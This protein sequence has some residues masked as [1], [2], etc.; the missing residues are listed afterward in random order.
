MKRWSVVALAVAMVMAA[1]CG[2]DDADAA[3]TQ[4]PGNTQSS[5]A[6]DTSPPATSAG[7]GNATTAAPPSDSGDSDADIAVVTIG[8]TT[9]RFGLG[10]QAFTRCDYNQFSTG[11]VFAAMVQ[12][13]DAGEPVLIEGAAAANVL[14][15]LNPDDYADLG[16]DAPGIEVKDRANDQEWIADIQDESDF[17]IDPGTSQVTSLT[18]DGRT[19]S[20]TATFYDR[21]T[22]FAWVGGTGDKPAGVEGTFEVTCAE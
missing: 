8:D 11:N 2:G 21:N 7:G 19:A 12:V 3:T 16:L 9:W 18:I 6:S 4:E 13:D 10:G 5:G 22:Y 20:G 1:G 15:E 14:L 17:D